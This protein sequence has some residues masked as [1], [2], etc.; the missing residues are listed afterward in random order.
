M[1]LNNELE[2]CVQILLLRIAVKLNIGHAKSCVCVETLDSCL[3]RAV[4]TAAH[5][6]LSHYIL[7]G[8]EP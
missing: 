5:A 6:L 7:T 3:E 8:I 4:D 2:R 1:Y